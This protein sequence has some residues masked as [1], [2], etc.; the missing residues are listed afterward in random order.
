MTPPPGPRGLP[1]LGNLLE[2]SRDV[3]DPYPRVLWT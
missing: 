3:R 2:F 1:L